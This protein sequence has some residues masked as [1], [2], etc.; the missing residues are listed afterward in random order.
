VKRLSF[1]IVLTV[2]GCG[3]SPQSTAQPIAPPR[4]PF[5]TTLSPSP[6]PTATGPVIETLYL[7]HNGLLVPR[8]RHVA[9]QSTVEEL[10]FDLLAGP[11][12]AESSDGL[13]SALAGVQVSGVRLQSGL[14]TVDLSE[15]IEGGGRNDELLAYA[16]V[17]CTLTGRAEVQ[18]VSFTRAGKPIDVPRGDSS[19]S[20]GPL[21]M[22]DYEQLLA[23]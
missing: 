20:P 22:R 3:I 7:V 14:A 11:T 19:V 8:V 9:S 23:H 6:V 5:L 21:T 4:A 15:P 1:L 2:A 16:Q 10:V 17:V 12:E 13:S 18:G